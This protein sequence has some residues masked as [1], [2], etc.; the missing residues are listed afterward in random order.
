MTRLGGKV[1]CR[2]Q[3][4]TG[5]TSEP[6]ANIHTITLNSLIPGRLWL[7][8]NPTV[9]SEPLGKAWMS[10]WLSCLP[11]VWV[12]PL[13]FCGISAKSCAWG[14]GVSLD[15]EPK[16]ETRFQKLCEQ[17]WEAVPGRSKDQVFQLSI[18]E[19][20]RHR[21]LRHLPVRI[22]L[23]KTQHTLLQQAEVWTWDG[24][25]YTVQNLTN[26]CRWLNATKSTSCSSLTWPV[27]GQQGALLHT[28]FKDPDGGWWR[29]YHSMAAPS[30][31][32]DLRGHLAGQEGDKEA[33]HWQLNAAA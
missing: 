3:E 22:H 29:F 8:Q 28:S 1:H 15:L 12:T 33:L 23:R 4:V 31:I 32:H 27:G 21:R 14:V 7:P 17:H 6:T 19:L 2:Q 24:L 5:P 10:Q 26:T 30:G 11:V 9:M 16:L 18:T 13:L 20:L 25:D